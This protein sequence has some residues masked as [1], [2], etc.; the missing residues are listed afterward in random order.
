MAT[1]GSPVP[2]R[3]SPVDRH[4]KEINPAV[5]AA[6]EEVIPSALEYG[7]KMLRDP[8]RV[9]NV[10]EEVAA[11]V[12]RQIASKDPPGDPLPI[13][14]LAGYVFRGFVRRV[15]R[16]KSKELQLVSSD[17]DGQ[18]RTEPSA[19]PTPDLL[20]KISL[21]QCLDQ[22]DFLTREMFYRRVEGLS[23]TEIGKIHGLSAHAAEVR[24][25]RALA[26]AKS[27]LRGAGRPLPCTTRT[28]RI[29]GLKPAMRTDVKK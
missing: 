1:H 7:L 3:L 2:L 21:D 26:A 15:N 29:E 5:L 11:A 16:L 6:A 22:F 9:T 4:G 28:D 27:R 17:S 12:S 23:W 10:L 25:R 18:P 20:T 8:A 14:N 24:F 19:D 13:Q